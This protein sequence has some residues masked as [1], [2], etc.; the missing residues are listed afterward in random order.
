M[1]LLPPVGEY[2]GEPVV[3]LDLAIPIENALRSRGI[4]LVYQSVEEADAMLR[5]LVGITLYI[6]GDEVMQI[7]IPILDLAGHRFGGF[8]QEPG[9]VGSVITDLDE[10]RMR[11]RCPGVRQTSGM[12]VRMP[13]RDW[14]K[15][16]YQEYVIGNAP[17]RHY[18]DTPG[19][20]QGFHIGPWDHLL[21]FEY[22]TI[23]DDVPIADSVP[24]GSIVRG[25]PLLIT[26]A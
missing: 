22:P 20:V 14:G 8:Q 25:D 5:G 24:G 23:S 7:G 4:P 12:I 19:C 21:G 18:L 1:P 2:G 13:Y 9:A 6:E 17:D 26:R 10:S 3:R 16:S 11:C 15:I